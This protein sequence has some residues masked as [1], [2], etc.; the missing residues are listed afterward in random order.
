RASA[1]HRPDADRLPRRGLPARLPAGARRPPAD[2]RVSP[3]P[4]G[5]GGLGRIPDGGPPLR[6]ARAD[7]R[8]AELLPARAGAPGRERH[9]LVLAGPA[10]A[11][12]GGGRRL[13][14]PGPRP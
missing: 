14:A 12:A 13:P 3:L 10:E 7:R 1:R 2:A 9:V 6:G 11:G 5:H 4:A 8:T